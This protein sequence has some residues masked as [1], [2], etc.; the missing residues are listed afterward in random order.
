M[1]CCPNKKLGLAFHLLFEDHLRLARAPYLSGY[2]IFVGKL[3]DWMK[4]SMN[5]E[6]AC[7]EGW[8]GDKSHVKSRQGAGV[9]ALTCHVSLSPLVGELSEPRALAYSSVCPL[10]SGTLLGREKMPSKYFL[11]GRRKRKV[12]SIV[13]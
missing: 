2:S 3:K 7:P 11:E 10:T 13:E 9:T 6:S 5:R 8:P 12:G 1:S 4:I